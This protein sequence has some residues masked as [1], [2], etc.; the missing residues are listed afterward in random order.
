VVYG[1]DDVA[2]EALYGYETL[3]VGTHGEIEHL[4]KTGAQRILRLAK[5]FRGSIWRFS[6]RGSKDHPAP[7]PVALPANCMEFYTKPGERVFDCCAG[8]GTT[9]IAAQEQDRV[10]YLMELSPRYC[11]LIIHRWE[12]LTGEK[13]VRIYGEDRQAIQT[14]ASGEA[15]T[16]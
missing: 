11:D 12:A 5:Q 9:L 8:S 16:A 6:G 14:H 15:A 7:F 3:W 10:A 1:N 13:A 2:I 4:P